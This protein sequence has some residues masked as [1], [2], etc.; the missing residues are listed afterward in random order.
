MKRHLCTK[1]R[2]KR[3]EKFLK[4]VRDSDKPNSKVWICVDNCLDGR[5]NSKA[6][7]FLQVG[8]SN[9]SKGLSNMQEVLSAQDL[10]KSDVA[11]NKFILDVCSANRMFWFNKNHDNVIY[12]DIKSDQDLTKS[13]V[14]RTIVQDFRNIKYKDKSLRLVVFDPPH[15]FKK[16]G[17]FSWLNERYG[18]LSIDNW[19]MDIKKGF[20]ECMR[21]LKD[22]GVLIFKWS[23][24]DISVS[25]VL[26]IIEETPL[27]G[28]TSDKKNKTHWFCFMKIPKT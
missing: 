8:L 13:F 22:Y 28:H 9:R 5:L 12:S 6:K 2:K 4:P 3:K 23:S 17:K 21:V 1:C 15:L 18:T 25:T 24:G 19:P 10:V 27:F 11:T 26:S 16:Q 20:D 7:S 14:A